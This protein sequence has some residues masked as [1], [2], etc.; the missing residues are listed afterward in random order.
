MA[1]I[2]KIKTLD[3]TTYDL[4]DATARKKVSND[5][6]WLT[7]NPFSTESVRGPYISKIDNALFAADKR[8]NVTATNTSGVSSLFDGSYES[9]V[10]IQNGVTSVITI[11][12]STESNGYFP[13]YPYGYILLSFYNVAGPASVSGRVYCNYE[14]HGIGWHDLSFSPLGDITSSNII[15]KS[16][17][18][19]YYAISKIEITVVGDT[20]NSY[21]YTGLTQ[22]EMHLT[23]PYPKYNPFLS[24][25]GAETLYYPLTA[26][27]FIG[28]LNGT[29][30][31]HAVNSDVPANAKFTDTTYNVATTSA[32]GL[33][34]STDKSKLD[35]ALAFTF[36]KNV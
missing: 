14:S 15:Y 25:Y 9:Q 26:P 19:G 6:E 22:I 1:D 4:K 24:K 27:S 3:G 17:H 32:N 36:V 10:I 28:D 30:N 13:G 7:T 21:G 29:V 16:A 34:S 31:G 20:T 12:F 8:W 35:S 2:S 33:M 18:Q 23:R 11:D 5:A